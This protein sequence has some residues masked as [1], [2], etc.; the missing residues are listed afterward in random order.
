MVF[1]QSD[2]LLMCQILSA[3]ELFLTTLNKLLYLTV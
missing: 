3:N 1:Q 2:M